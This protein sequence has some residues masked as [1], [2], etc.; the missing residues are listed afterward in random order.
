MVS[1]KFT[2]EMRQMLK[3][4]VGKIFVSYEYLKENNLPNQTYGNLRIHMEDCAIDLTNEE[5]TFPFFDGRE[6][7]SCFSCKRVD[8]NVPFQPFV[9][10]DARTVAY[11]VGEQIARV[12][13]MNDT[14]NINQGEYVISFDTALI[15]QT[16]SHIY[17]FA[18]GLW[19]SE[20]I[21]IRSDD[22]YEKVLSMEKLIDS[23]SNEGEDSV[24][25]KRTITSL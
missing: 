15:I 5:K 22:D 4:M 2:S 18:R 20:I 25:I 19:F 16:T 3:N 23:W 12:E 10:T 14:I 7:M 21:S 8:K 6:D 11:E 9:V 24:K 1:A 13:I 17:M